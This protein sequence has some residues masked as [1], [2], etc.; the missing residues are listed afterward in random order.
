MYDKFTN[1]GGVVWRDHVGETHM[2][3]QH[4]CASEFFS[5]QLSLVNTQL[6]DVRTCRVGFFQKILMAISS[7]SGNTRWADSRRFASD[8][9]DRLHSRMFKFCGSFPVKLRDGLDVS[10]FT[11]VRTSRITAKVLI[12]ITLVLF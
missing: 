10:R 9:S 1:V 11:I 7:G 2:A 12:G 3:T 5:V 4:M 6:H 8:A